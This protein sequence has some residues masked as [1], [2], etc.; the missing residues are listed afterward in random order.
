MAS[1]SPFRLLLAT[2]LLGAAWGLVKMTSEAPIDVVFEVN[3]GGDAAQSKSFTVRVHPDWAPKGAQQFLQL[4]KQGWYSDAAV[5]RVKPHFVA[6]FGLPAVPHPELPSIQDDPVKMSNKRGT[7]TFATAGKN[8]RTSQLFF[9][10]GDNSFLDGQGFSPF[11]EVLGD[12]M[13]A[14]DAFFKGYGE[15]P[16]QGLIRQKGNEYLDKH[17]PKLAKISKVSISA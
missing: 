14:V 13:Q 9:N 7:L 2:S 16:S 12:G 17:F 8:T 11:A 3:T 15:E 6:Q 5:F 10:Y 4:V 1:L